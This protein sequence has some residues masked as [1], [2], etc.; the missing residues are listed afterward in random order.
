MEQVVLGELSWG[1]LL[2][3]VGTWASVGIPGGVRDVT[4]D[5]APS[6]LGD[7]LERA[8]WALKTAG[9]WGAGCRDPGDF[10]PGTHS[11]FHKNE[12]T[13]QYRTSKRFMKG[14]SVRFMS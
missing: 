4:V 1:T 7:R 12:Q 5:E 8:P 6:W 3:E 14:D 13:K 9:G 2:Q 10:S 11:L